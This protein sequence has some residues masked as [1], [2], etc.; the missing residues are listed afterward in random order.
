MKAR[1][2][3]DAVWC[4]RPDKHTNI[5]WMTIQA[6][7]ANAAVS[8]DLAPDGKE[9]FRLQL[10]REFRIEEINPVTSTEHPPLLQIA[11]LFAGIAVFSRDKFQEYTEWKLNSTGQSRLSQFSSIEDSI[12]NQC[13]N[14]VSNKDHERFC[15]LQYF[16]SLCK[17]AKLGVSLKERK[18]LWT[19]NPE[20]PI[21]FWPYEPQHPSDKA[22]LRG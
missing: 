5:D 10:R 22:P 14:N 19:P 17:K 15:V 11:D 9:G 8:I 16:D 3:E 18:G 21:N 2:P 13:S 4:F 12:T 20:N 1:W 6:C 7:L